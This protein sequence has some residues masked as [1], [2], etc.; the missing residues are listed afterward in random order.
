MTY[1]YNGFKLVGNPYSCNGYLSFTPASGQTPTEVNFYVLN[2]AGDKFTLSESSVALA[3]CTGAFFYADADGAI[4]FSSEVP[5]TKARTGMLNISLTQEGDVVDMAR[6]RFG[7]GMRLAK[8][9]FRNDNST[10]YIPQNDKNYAVVY[11]EATGEMPLNFKAETTG[12]HTI[13]FKLDGA[14]VDYLHLYDKLTGEDIN[15]LI[16]PEYSFIGSIID[17]TDRFVVRFSET[18]AN[19]VF[20]YQSGNDIIVNGNGELQVFDIMGRMVMNTTVNGTTTVNLPSNAVYIFRMVGETVNTQK[21][22]VR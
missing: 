8:Q 17:A 7:E 20:A 22:V 12:T 9:S 14:S 15:L 11:T 4:N 21:I 10:I 13:S 1:D 5:A 19:S 16:T 3:P 6:I 2:S 18:A